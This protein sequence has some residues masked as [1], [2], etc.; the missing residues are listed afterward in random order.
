MTLKE[1][2]NALLS[3]RGVLAAAIVDYESG[4]IM[5]SGNK[6]PDLDIEIIMASGSN[7]IRAKKRT[8]ALLEADDFIHDILISSATQYHLLCPCYHRENMFIYMV[9][10]R[11][12]ANLSRCRQALFQAERMVV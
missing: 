8:I 11:K 7:I 1:I 12:T 4:M 6:S 9:L 10:D 5:A 2:T 3:L